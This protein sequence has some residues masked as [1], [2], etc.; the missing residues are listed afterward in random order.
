MTEK[1]RYSLKKRMIA[2]LAGSLSFLVGLIL[3]TIFLP[4]A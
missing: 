2:L 3:F 1:H 4:K